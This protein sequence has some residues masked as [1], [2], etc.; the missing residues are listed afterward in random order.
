MV[1]MVN[2]VRIYSLE[3]KQHLCR[4]ELS[5][6]T[7][8]GFNTQQSCEKLLPLKRLLTEVLN[9]SEQVF[10]PPSLPLIAFL[11]HRVLLCKSQTE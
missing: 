5:R 10:T 2:I 9:R 4:V 7:R 6:E 1:T 8:E 11:F 3:S